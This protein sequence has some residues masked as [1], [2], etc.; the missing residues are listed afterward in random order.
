M[1]RLDRYVGRIVAGA[2]FSCLMFLLFLSV[3]IDLLNFLPNYLG[4]ADQ[5]GLGELL[6]QLACFYLQMV[7]TFFVSVAPFVTVMACMFAATRLM[8]SQEL[9][10]MLFAGRS[11]MRVLRPFLVC[12]GASAV[13][14]AACWEWGLPHL[15]ASF[16]HIQDALHGKKEDK[17]EAKDPKDQKEQ[18]S[19]EPDDRE[20]LSRLVLS[21]D[22]DPP[23]K[24]SIQGYRLDQ[25]RMRGVVLVLLHPPGEA[26]LVEAD[27]AVWDA[28]VGDWRL[29]HGR[30]GHGIPPDWHEGARE[31]LQEGDLT[32]DRVARNGREQVDMDFLSYG[33]LVE[34]AQRRPLRADVKLTLQRRISYPLANLL[35]VLLAMPVTIHFER[36]S[37]IERVLGA[38]LFCGA[39]LV[40]DL[41]CQSLG[42][43]GFVNPIV[44]AWTPT[45]L[46]GSLGLVMF[47]S[48]KT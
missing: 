21:L 46:F 25:Q 24:L 40:T 35:L 2:W 18:E 9:H 29:E 41:T 23:R 5:L 34:L 1:D 6:F 3:L 43:R 30:V 22:G 36:K 45:I 26:E 12:A 37:R 42:L 39:Y 38:I 48:L 8:A 7:P 15:G 44:A 13:A 14:M 11:T 10:P 28:R 27:A 16:T 47:G 19:Q 33:E 31:W 17:K 4:K 32:P 20:E